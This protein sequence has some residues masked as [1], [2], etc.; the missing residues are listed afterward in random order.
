MSCR[1]IHNNI[2]NGKISIFG[3]TITA[4][5]QNLSLQ[6]CFAFFTGEDIFGQ[7]QQLKIRKE[8]L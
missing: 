5:K 1:T 3:Y 2:E 8:K 4:Y 7:F 6:M